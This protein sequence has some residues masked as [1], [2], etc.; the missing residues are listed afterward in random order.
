[1]M[2]TDPVGNEAYLDKRKCSLHLTND[3]ALLSTI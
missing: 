3:A 1:M 2:S